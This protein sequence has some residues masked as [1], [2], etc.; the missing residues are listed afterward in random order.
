MENILNDKYMSELSDTP[1]YGRNMPC[2]TLKEIYDS[3]GTYLYGNYA[4]PYKTKSDLDTI[5]KNNVITDRSKINRSSVLYFDKSCTFPRYKLQDTTFKR[6]IKL[7]KADY[8]VIPRLSKS[9][10][11]GEFSSKSIKY[12]C[13]YNSRELYFTETLYNKYSSL[14]NI[15]EEIENSSFMYTSSKEEACLINN[16]FT[17]YNN[18][19]IIYEDELDFII[20]SNLEKLD[21]ESMFSIYE[22]LNSS[23]YSSVELGCKL[24]TSFNVF[25][26]SLTVAFLLFLTQDH[27]IQNKAAK[28]VGFQSMLQTLNYPTSGFGYIDPIFEKYTIQCEEDKELVKKLFK[29]WITK[30]LKDETNISLDKCPFKVEIEI[31]VE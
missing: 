24:L 31:T 20:S 23:D 6:C 8:V 13:Y 1:R 25:E 29:P 17:L 21:E 18:K 12:K 22:M 30:L 11:T 27:W 15:A 26:T 10:V 4:I 14:R 7:D 5:L 9:V 19:S 2:D 3:L 28:S 16:I